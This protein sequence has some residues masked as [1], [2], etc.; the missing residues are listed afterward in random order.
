MVTKRS[1]LAFFSSGFTA[2]NLDFKKDISVYI[3]ISKESQN[4]KNTWS[5][6]LLIIG[7]VTVCHSTHVATIFSFPMLMTGIKII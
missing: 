3:I 2:R 7:A 5:S 4:C 1:G 6:R